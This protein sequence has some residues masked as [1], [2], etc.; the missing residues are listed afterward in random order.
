MWASKLVPS[1]QVLI[2]K[3]ILYTVSYK[4]HLELWYVPNLV[5]FVQCT[6]KYDIYKYIL[7]AHLRST[8]CRLSFLSLL[9]PFITCSSCCYNLL[10]TILKTYLK[11]INYKI[12]N[13][14][15]LFN[16]STLFT[17][18]TSLLFYKSC[19]LAYFKFP[20]ISRNIILII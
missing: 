17:T 12:E 18:S 20:S 5:C 19:T 10:K 15:N 16:I 14:V 8:I 11:R 4:S 13:Q 6:F 2:S 1:S 9:C 7:S 3:F